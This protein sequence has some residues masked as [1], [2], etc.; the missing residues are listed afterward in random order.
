MSRVAAVQMASG[1]NVGAN[2]GEAERHIAAAAQAGA[3]LVVLPENFAFMGKQDADM[4]EVRE[5]DGDGPIQ[6]FLAEQA[7]KHSIWLVGGTVPLA[8]DN[9]QRVR[10]ACLLYDE[11]GERAARYDKM[12]LFD[13]CLPE[14]GERYSESNTF[15]PGG[16]VVV[17]ETPIG[18]LGLAI[19][20]DLRFPELFRV[21]VD[22]GVEIIALPSAFTA[23]TGKAHWEPL[24]RARAI[25]NLSFVVAGAQG[26]YHHS[27]RETHGHAMIVDPWGT[28]LAQ[29]PRGNGMVHAAVDRQLLQATRQKF[30]ALDHRRLHCK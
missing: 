3:R 18:R 24:I 13:V 17:V 27:G 16:G 14:S 5:A 21:M 1:P 23:Q 11:R 4:L 25:E 29:Q 7:A 22:Q 9:P 2:L 20:Y 26:G 8:G 10:S 28:I 12:H 15:E 6:R 19:C 30:P